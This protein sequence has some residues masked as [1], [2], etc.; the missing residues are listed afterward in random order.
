MGTGLGA[1]LHR[2]SSLALHLRDSDDPEEPDGRLK[3]QHIWC[4]P[5]EVARGTGA[6][7]KDARREH[8]RRDD[9]RQIC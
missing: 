5:R 3:S 8:E 2:P 7:Q 6:E 9:E 1:V 4:A